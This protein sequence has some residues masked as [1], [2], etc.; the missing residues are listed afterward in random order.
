[1]TDIRVAFEMAA[2]ST[3]SFSFKFES[4]HSPSSPIGR[5]PADTNGPATMNRE[6]MASH[7]GVIAK[8][9]TGG[10]S[11]EP[12]SDS[13]ARELAARLSLEEQVRIKAF[14][15]FSL[16]FRECKLF[17]FLL[18][19]FLPSFP[20][21]WS[22]YVGKLVTASGV[23]PWKSCTSPDMLPLPIDEESFASSGR[24]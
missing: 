10:A 18:V 23:G 16:A 19:S 17:S 9:G 21:F 12:I 13:R 2:S 22:D 5:A 15:I 7:P 14:R 11:I 4:R 8:K 6:R 24:M 1:M 20:S 3:D